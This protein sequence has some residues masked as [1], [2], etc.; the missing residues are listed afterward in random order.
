MPL[1][2]PPAKLRWPRLFGKTG[3]IRYFWNLL[4]WVDQ[5]FNTLA[6]GEPDETLSSRMGK[7]A[8]RGRGW[9]PCQLC[10]LLSFFDENHCEKN[11]ELDEGE[12]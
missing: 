8:A 11:I 9:I 5:G 2:P 7:Y 4:I 12:K 3:M 1:I 6:G 10:K